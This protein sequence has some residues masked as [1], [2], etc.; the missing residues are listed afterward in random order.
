MRTT[1]WTLASILA[2]TLA[3]GG[4]GGGGGGDSVLGAPAARNATVSILL[5]DAPSTQWDQAIATVTS[6]QLIGSAGTVTLF[7]GSRTL[8]LLKLR[9]F[10]ELFAVS[11]Q[12][13]AGSY[14]KIRLQVTNLELRDL[15]DA[16]NV[17]DSQRTQLVGNGK[18]D[19]NPRGPFTLQGGDVVF[20]EL[21]FDMDKALK[22]TTTGGG[23]I[24][25]RPVVFVNIRTLQPDGR[26]ARIHGRV[27]DINAGAGALRLCQ[28]R[29]A[30]AEPPPPVGQDGGFGAVH[31]VTVRTDGATGIFDSDGL[32][33]DFTGLAVGEAVTAIGRLRPLDA[34]RQGRGDD[35]FGY[36]GQPLALD[37]VIIEEGPFGTFRRV[38]GTADSAVDPG[39][40]VFGLGVAPGQGFS[41]GTVLPVQLY[42]ASRIFN[43]RGVELHA[44]DIE[45]GDALLADGVLHIGG[46]TVLRSP[47]VILDPGP[48]PGAAELAGTVVS[49]DAAHMSL[50]VNDGSVDRCVDAAQAQVFAVSAADGFSSTRIDLAGLRA[51]QH[52]VAF[53][54]ERLDGCFVADTLIA[55]AD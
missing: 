43:R 9:D 54:V 30:S 1:S 49:V 28:S 38:R 51:G 55:D 19:L 33:Q 44:A 42:D 24:I 23:R 34:T 5:A 32:P 12:V 14:S 3:L 21:D 46:A 35:D 7:S 22:L 47:L 15:D 10:S 6:V 36:R 4:C 48:V 25:L 45:P 39:T 16:G 41:T 27:T 17:I 2:A 11:D 53:G 26:L 13:P 29:F 31:C 52:V 8:D 18:I 40:Q 20:V 37:A 50:R